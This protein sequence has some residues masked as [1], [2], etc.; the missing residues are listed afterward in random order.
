MNEQNGNYKDKTMLVVLAHPDDESFGMGGTLAYYADK[1]VNI[2]Y[3]CGT[4]GE[5]GTLD[6]DCL[7]GFDSVGERRESELMCA[8]DVLGLS[9]VSFL[10]FRDSGMLGSPD[11]DHPNAL[12]AQPVDKVAERITHFIRRIKPDII[13]TH[14]PVGGYHHPDHIAIHKATVKAFHAAADPNM[15]QNG[16][17]P[18]QPQRL[19]YGVF[20]RRLFRVLVWAL[21][22]IGRDP[23]K[24]G[25]NQDI[26]LEMLA[27]DPDYPQHVKIN[28][29][30]Y[31]ER[32]AK[33]D[34]CHESQLDLGSQGSGIFFWLREKLI[35]GTDGYMQAYPEIP[36]NAH[37]K[38]LFEGLQ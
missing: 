31:K 8:A 34:A 26:N 35:P 38:D 5:S 18:H 16:L 23:S 14:D 22:V 28:Y 20:P 25:R 33:A 24:F 4:R 3:L 29:T 1:G 36:A 9:S 10:G 17:E 2:H 15:Y 12:V 21:K 30:K 37:M 11:N 6:A 7:D 32:K 27:K 13:V 19:Y